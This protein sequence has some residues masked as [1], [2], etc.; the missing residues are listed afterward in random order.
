[1]KGI[2]RRQ[3][4]E[5]GAKLVALMSLS[6]T[7]APS[8]AEA[9][10]GLASGDTP[11]LW[12][13]GQSCS[14]C[15]VSLLNSDHPGPVQ[16][17]TQSI[18]LQFHATLS[19]ATGHLGVEVINKNIDSGGFILIVEGAMP[20]DM[21][22]ACTMAREPVTKQVT[23]AARKAK[24]ILAVGA[25][26]AFGGIP[27]AQNNPTGAVSVPEFLNNQGIKTPV[28]RIPGCPAHP[29][30]MIGTLVHLLSFGSPK[31]DDIGRPEVFFQRLIHDQ[32]PRFADYERE[33]FAQTFSEEGCLFKL[34]CLGP[35]T[36]ADC[37]LRLW[38]Q[39]TNTCII[40]GGPC[41]GCASEEYARVAAFP[42]YRKNPQ[43]GG[44]DEQG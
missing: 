1:M 35:I 19:V 43:P 5:Y 25:C 44:K 37:N 2:S 34:G 30:W 18:A 42:F 20:V 22:R 8:A 38:N 21:P 23:R 14:G 3:F 24:A 39:G 10:E 27:A 40:A 16:I 28:I 12:L 13:Q 17:I 6:P 7:L 9:L 33:K 26:A 31:L 15:S 41:I 29:D 11:V 36:K 4:L 32:C